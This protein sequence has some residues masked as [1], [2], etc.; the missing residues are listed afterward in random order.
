MKKIIS[1]FLAMLM[2][3]SVVT[4]AFAAD[5]D[6]TDTPAATDTTGTDTEETTEEEFEITDLPIWT[7]GAGFKIGKI[8]LKLAKAF[9]KVASA[10]GLIDV[11][12]LLQNLISQITNKDADTDTTTEVVDQTPADQPVD[13]VTP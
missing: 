10:L 9:L 1:V 13:P 6:V 7:V 3:F 12:E 8:I 5:G 11:S 2:I 4:V